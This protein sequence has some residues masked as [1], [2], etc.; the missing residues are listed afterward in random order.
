M[1]KRKA[2]TPARIESADTRKQFGLRTSAL[3]SIGVIMESVKIYHRRRVLE[4][5][6]VLFSPEK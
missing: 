5:A 6:L 4:A 3:K 1:A 2:K